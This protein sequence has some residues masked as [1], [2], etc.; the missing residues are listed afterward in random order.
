MKNKKT[1]VAILLLILVVLVAV[2]CWFTFGPKGMAGRK[3]IIVDITHGDGSVKTI[4]IDTK[5]EFLGEAMMEENLLDGEEGPYGLYVTTVDGET[6]DDSK[7]EWWGY[8]KSGQYVEY[9]VDMCPIAD[10]DHYEF[11]FNVG[12][13]F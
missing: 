5:A 2:I 6:A 7:E 13:D 1:V 12:Y 9:G 3:N 8:T 10:G 11:T 4:E